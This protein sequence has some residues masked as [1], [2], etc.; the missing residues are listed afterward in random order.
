MTEEDFRLVV[1]TF[2]SVFPHALLLSNGRAACPRRLQP[3]VPLA[4]LAFLD[5]SLGKG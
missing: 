2:T 1:R 5:L 3:G 4:E